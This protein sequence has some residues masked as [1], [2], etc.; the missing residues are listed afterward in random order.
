M[1]YN[2]QYTKEEYEQQLP[3]LAKQ[4]LA[5]VLV[6]IKQQATY[7]YASGINNGGHIFGDHISGSENITF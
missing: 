1:I 4:D 2:K 5:T 6:R 3:Q 7:K